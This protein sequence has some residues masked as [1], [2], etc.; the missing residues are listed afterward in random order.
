[1]ASSSS[2]TE[3]QSD[4]R[5]AAAAVAFLGPITS[6]THQA[7]RNGGFDE[8]NWA[9]IPVT[10][11]IDVFG[12]V[13]SGRACFG[14]VPFE[15]STHGTVT[16]CLSGLADR[17]SRYPDVSVCAEI[18][19][20]VHHYLLGHK[21]SNS[22]SGA[23]EGGGFG[24]VKRIYSHPQAFGQTV[25]WVA[26]NLR[27]GGRAV[28]C[29]EVSSTSRA[30]EL[31]ALDNRR[32]G[33]DGEEGG[34][35]GSSSSAAI[36]SQ[37][38]GEHFGLDVLARN[39]EDRAD[40][41]TRFFVLERHNNKNEGGDGNGKAQ[42]PEKLAGR[43]GHKTLVSFTVSHRKPGALADVLDV[44]RRRQ[45]NLT[46]INSL[47]S[48]V[49]PFNYL[50]FVEFEGSSRHEGGEKDDAAGK[51]VEG[52]MQEVAK[53]AERSRWLGSWVNQRS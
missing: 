31:A 3:Q 11:I 8:Q 12:E 28:E 46:S 27:S 6:Y 20:D 24:H 51:N 16:Q 10:N 38:A 14:V 41:V 33:E 17:S 49:E 52:A 21:A 30:A 13:Q 5:T 34:G 45:L 35:P 26:E 47:P 42:L 7:T 19:L 39:I 2:S 53:L 1:M 18:Y 32:S 23:D 44:F 37:M 9:L 25:N 40:N 43:K 22:G 4:R 36:A 48:L 15:N 29:I 50:F